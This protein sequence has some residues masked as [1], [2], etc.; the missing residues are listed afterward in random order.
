MKFKVLKELEIILRYP[1]VFFFK[2]NTYI[3]GSDVVNSKNNQKQY[4]PCFYKLDDEFN[5]ISEKKI[6]E[7]F[8]RSDINISLWIRDININ[9]EGIF[10]NFELKENINN[11]SYKH[12]NYLVFT[13]DLEKF[14]FVKKYDYNIFIFKDF[15]N[16]LLM[17]NLTKDEEFPDFFWGKYLFEFIIN[18]EKIIP[19]FDNIV[20]Y[21]KDKGHLVHDV[22]KKNGGVYDMLFS[23]R[24]LINNTPDFIYKFYT[25]KTT[26]FINFYD[27]KEIIIENNINDTKWCSYPNIFKKNTNLYSVTNQDDFGKN[28]NVLLCKVEL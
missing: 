24:H 5:I 10:F 22:L 18:G 8:D 4:W 11:E 19:T 28:K 3:I 27:T 1:K 14:E 15:E 9:E 21:K 7:T 23:I 16:R 12:N 17:S 6:F 13:N 2:N 26:D 20:D 25:S